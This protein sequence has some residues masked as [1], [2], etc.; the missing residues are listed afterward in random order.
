MPKQKATNNAFEV[1][2][3]VKDKELTPKDIEEAIKKKK[4]PFCGYSI[5]FNATIEAYRD[6]YFSVSEKGKIEWCDEVETPGDQGSRSDLAPNP[7]IICGTCCKEIPKEVW[8]EWFSNE[9]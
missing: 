2:K 4:C 1:A 7:T 8:K 5:L 6:F 9:A 3:K